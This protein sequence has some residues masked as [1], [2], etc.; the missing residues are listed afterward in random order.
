MLEIE[1]VLRMEVDL[2]DRDELPSTW[3]VLP[4]NRNS[5]MSRS[6]GASRQPESLTLSRSSRGA[7]HVW[8]LVVPGW[9]WAWHHP[10]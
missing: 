1:A 7:P 8:Q 4:E 9:F 10:H 2:G 3:Q 6:R 5:V